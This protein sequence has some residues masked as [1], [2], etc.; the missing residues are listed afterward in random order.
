MHQDWH[1]Q[2]IS[3][4]WELAKRR[5]LTADDIPALL[6]EQLKTSLRI[7]RRIQHMQESQ[8]DFDSQLQSFFTSF[9][10]YTSAV[11][12]Y[13]AAIPPTVKV[14]LATEGA[15]VAAAVTQLNTAMGLIPSS[16]PA[17]VVA[18]PP[19]TAPPAPGA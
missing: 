9:T 15:A 16:Q 8:A 7:E 12:A 6:A 3:Y 2:Q 13:I 1:E 11:E 10:S 19:V 5:D 4:A 18:P 14:N 17:P